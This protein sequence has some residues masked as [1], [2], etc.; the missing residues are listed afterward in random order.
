MANVYK[1]LY[2]IVPPVDHVYSSVCIYT[3]V[4]PKVMP[5]T[6]LCWPTM[7]EV[8]IGGMAVE[9]EPSHQCSFLLLLLYD[10]WQQRGSLTKWSLKWKYV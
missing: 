8:D 6:L 9:A 10:R 5:P 7:S 2:M 1:F 3:Q 4:A